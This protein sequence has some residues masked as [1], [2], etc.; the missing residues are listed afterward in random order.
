LAVWKGVVMAEI[1]ISPAGASPG[2]SG[3]DINALGNLLDK[4]NSAAKSFEGIMKTVQ[5]MRDGAGA[6]QQNNLT[7]EQRRAGSVHNNVGAEPIR[8][9]KPAAKPQPAPDTS[10]VIK[11]SISDVLLLAA[12]GKLETAVGAG[13]GGIK[14]MKFLNDKDPTL[15]DLYNMIE[16]QIKELKKK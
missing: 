6:A 15:Q 4:V 9:S 8:I 16:S 2:G 11:D 7:L 1:I 12:L 3:F 14:I 13:L 10:A 5:G